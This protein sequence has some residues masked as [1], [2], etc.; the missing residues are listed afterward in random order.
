[1]LRGY[2]RF[3]PVVIAFTLG[4]MIAPVRGQAEERVS[5]P[6]TQ[7]LRAA[8]VLSPKVE[9]SDDKSF[10]Y[11]IRR[12][13]E[14]AGEKVKI[15][16]KTHQQANTD[17]EE[18][19]IAN[20]AK[21]GVDLIIAVSF[22]DIS[23]LLS[24]AE[25]YPHVKFVVID[26]VVPP[27]Y[28]NV[29]SIIF[30]EHEGSFLVGMIAA[31]KSRTGMI[32]FVG[33]RDVTLIRNFAYGYKQ[34]A[35]YV[36]PNISVVENWIGT[37]PEAWDDP[38]KGEAIAKE[39]FAKGVDI[40]FAAAGASGLG[41]LKAASETKDRFAIG[42]DSNQNGLYPG[43][44]LTSMVKKVDVAV[45]KALLDAAHGN[46][47]AGIMN[48]GLREGAINFAL[49]DNNKALLNA[50]QLAL[51]EKARQQIVDG[52]LEVKMYTPK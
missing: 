40:T 51:V 45:Y 22:V 25:K 24:V 10:L 49:D 37:G 36:N 21:S 26:G 1:M 30:R 34:G 6:Q 50:D 47:S 39:Q 52:R 8:I 17:D 13:A 19:F 3:L 7:T 23:N 20:V 41:V 48:L 32:G 9:A 12:G 11:A 14:R 28:P 42:V 33:G 38:A 15:D 2:L 16:L 43:R 46:W 27:L 35:Q 5:Q 4:A 18:S 44:V 31:M 29:K